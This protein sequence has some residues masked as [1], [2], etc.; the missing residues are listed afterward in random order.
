MQLLHEKPSC[1]RMSDYYQNSSSIMLAIRCLLRW[2]RPHTVTT[3]CI[4]YNARCPWLIKVIAANTEFEWYED[5][6]HESGIFKGIF[7]FVYAVC[8]FLN[9]MCLLKIDRHEV[10]DENGEVLDK[11]VA[12]AREDLES[13]FQLLF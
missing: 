10:L 3:V 7:S 13:R 12:R 2:I 11:N 8:E 4:K 9:E 6:V 5:M 1:T